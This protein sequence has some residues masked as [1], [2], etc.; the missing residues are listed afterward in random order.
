MAKRKPSCHKSITWF[1][2]FCVVIEK[3]GSS[4]LISFKVRT[5]KNDAIKIVHAI[6]ISAP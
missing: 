6:V 2:S 4:L 3:K 5:M 1:S